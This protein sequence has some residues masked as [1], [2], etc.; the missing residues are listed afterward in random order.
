MFTGVQPIYQPDQNL[1]HGHEF[2]ELSLK[3][4]EE[5]KRSVHEKPST[6]DTEI[7]DI[8]SEIDKSAQEIRRLK[9]SII[10]EFDLIQDITTPDWRIRFQE[11]PG[12]D[13]AS[14]MH[15]PALQSENLEYLR[16]LDQKNFEE[17]CMTSRAEPNKLKKTIDELGGISNEEFDSI[18]KHLKEI[19]KDFKQRAKD[20]NEMRSSL[21]S[22]YLNMRELIKRNLPR[23]ELDSIWRVLVKME[24][25]FHSTFQRI[26]NTIGGIHCEVNES[27][28]SSENLW[29]IF[30]A[31]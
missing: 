17:E 6:L 9:Q 3:D 1:Q 22:N 2:I 19:K 11:L 18:F 29:M 25:K 26:D 8:E 7:L 30:L 14:M 28:G 20:L 21:E 23:E 5:L 13:P 24:T 16:K 31:T 10:C 27:N 15:S 12:E 4:L